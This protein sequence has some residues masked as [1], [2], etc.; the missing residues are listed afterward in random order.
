MVCYHGLSIE[1]AIMC[2]NGKR[3]QFMMTPVVLRD[4][5]ALWLDYVSQAKR[6]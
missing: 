2:L 5:L 3:R 6:L 1:N 4:N